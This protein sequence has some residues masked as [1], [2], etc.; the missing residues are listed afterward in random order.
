[1]T[2]FNEKAVEAAAQER[3]AQAAAERGRPA[4]PWDGHYSTATK[5]VLAAY[6]DSLAEQGIALVEKPR[7]A[8]RAA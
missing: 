7:P 1:M 4:E 5:A 3:Y 8:P 2:A 6:F